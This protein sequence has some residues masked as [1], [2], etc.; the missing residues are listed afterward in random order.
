MTEPGPVDA[1]VKR[2]ALALDALDAAVERRRE[3][4]RGANDLASQVHSLG[5]DRSKLAA[6]LDGET[7]R[8]RALEQTNRDIA[9]RIDAAIGSIRAVIAANGQT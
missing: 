1:A 4:D 7:A 2:L 8:V 9:Q 6:A 3:A 5:S